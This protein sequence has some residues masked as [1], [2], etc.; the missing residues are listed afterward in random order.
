MRALRSL[1]AAAVVL[2]ASAARA[3]APSTVGAP[4]IGDPYFPFAGN[5][6]LDVTDYGLALSYD[7]AA[8]RLTGTS[9]LRITATQ[10]LT[11]F[12]LD[13]RGFEVGTVTVDGAPAAAVARDG[14]ELVITPARRIR[15]GTAFT[16]VVPYAATPET[17]P[18]PDGSSEGWVY[19]A[20]GAAV[21]GEPQ[22]SPGWYPVNDTPRDKATY[23]ISMTVPAGLTAV[24]NGSLVSQT[25]SG[26]GTTFVWRE[27]FPM[28]PYLSTITLGRFDV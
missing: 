21:V 6:G 27:R 12:D 22:G 5:G 23:T 11:R 24:G 14:Q 19:T 26:G 8:R 10:A 28:A 2:A 7:P 1:L 17:V 18:D 25:P 3:A 20:D 4:G 16:V 15:R 13:L 9:T